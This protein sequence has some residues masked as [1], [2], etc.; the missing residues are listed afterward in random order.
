MN[1]R[2]LLSLQIVKKSFCYQ[3][4]DKRMTSENFPSNQE[5]ME[6]NQNKLFSIQ[7]RALVLGMKKKWRVRNLKRAPI[8]SQDRRN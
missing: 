1:N 2:I 3:K 4:R 7:E 5:L 6:I 8:G